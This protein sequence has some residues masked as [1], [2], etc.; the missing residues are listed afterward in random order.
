MVGTVVST[1]IQCGGDGFIFRARF[2][3]KLEEREFTKER[4]LRREP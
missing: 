3:G 2:S 4:N 1:F